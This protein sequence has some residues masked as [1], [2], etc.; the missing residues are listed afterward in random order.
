MENNS[1]RA[2]KVGAPALVVMS[3]KDLA[4]LGGGKV[5]YIKV[6]TTD[7]AKAMFPAVQGIPAG[8]RLYALNAADGTPIALT[9][10]HQAAVGQAMGDE[11]EI[12]SLH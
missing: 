8:I 6:L 9:D 4:N 12:A 11:L 5:A 3:A 2:S 7:E 1:A 10:S